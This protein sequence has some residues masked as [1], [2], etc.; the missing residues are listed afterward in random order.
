MALGI[1]DHLTNCPYW[2]FIVFPPNQPFNFRTPINMAQ[3]KLICS[4]NLF[5]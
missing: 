2:Q 4:F 1:N 5:I 3:N